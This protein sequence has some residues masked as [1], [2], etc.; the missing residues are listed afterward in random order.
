MGVTEVFA[1]KE[2]YGLEAQTWSIV[3]LLLSVKEP[4]QEQRYHIVGLT[5]GGTNFR[6]TRPSAMGTQ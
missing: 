5:T 1:P 3:L 2:R 6:G 4:V